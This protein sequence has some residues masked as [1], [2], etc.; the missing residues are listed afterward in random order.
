M[1]CWI[2][3]K[4][5][6]NKGLRLHEKEEINAHRH[7]HTYRLTGPHCRCASGLRNI[8][9]I[10]MGLRLLSY[11][12]SQPSQP[13]LQRKEH[14]AIV[15]YLIYNYQR[16]RKKKKEKKGSKLFFFFFGATLHLASSMP[17]SIQYISDSSP[18][19]FYV[20]S[21][22]IFFTFSN[23]LTKFISTTC[24]QISQP[25][26]HATADHVPSLT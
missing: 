26:C 17:L 24:Q 25:S 23:L 3:Q 12:D 13:C 4:R 22:S 15:V 9:C 20:L 2:W 8:P 18:L 7:V 5:K 1:T 14:R 16:R 21:C 6:K 10:P 19:L 11:S